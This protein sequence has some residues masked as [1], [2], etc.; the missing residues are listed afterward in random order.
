MTNFLPRFFKLHTNTSDFHSLNVT[1]V[2]KG[3]GK[4]NETE[5]SNKESYNFNSC[6][7]L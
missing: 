2:N 5:L 1:D 7:I 6:Y 3:H 4:I